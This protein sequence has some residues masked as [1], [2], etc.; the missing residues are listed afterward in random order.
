MGA[1]SGAVKVPLAAALLVAPDRHSFELHLVARCALI[2]LPRERL[3]YVVWGVVEGREAAAGSRGRLSWADRKSQEAPLGYMF[4]NA[5]LLTHGGSWAHHG[6][7][8]ELGKLCLWARNTAAGCGAS[9][10]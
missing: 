9:S 10:R 8:R 2:L 6:V 7:E 5:L 1:P 4:R 3:V